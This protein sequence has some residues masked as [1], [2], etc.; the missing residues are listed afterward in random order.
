M[1]TTILTKRTCA[2][3]VP[4]LIALVETSSK[5]IG[6]AIVI[7]VTQ[8][9][10]MVLQNFQVL[11]AVTELAPAII[12]PKFDGCAV[13]HKS[14]QIA[15]TIQVFQGHDLGGGATQG[16]STIGQGAI[17]I[18]EPDLIGSIISDE[19]VKVSIAVEEGFPRL[20]VDPALMK[21]V[22]INLITNAVQAMPEGGKLT[23]RASRT[24]ETASISIQDTGVGIP[25][26]DLPRL[27]QPL[28]TT[29]PRGQGFGLPVCQRLVEAHGGS[30]TVESEVGVG[31]TFTVQ[32]PL[33]RR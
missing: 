18:V 6:S 33:R 25:G 17:A 19:S 1:P 22:L 15:V 4:D 32:I 12:P 26:E 3:V 13:S 16:L 2:I 30:I 21:R 8:G 29:K 28:F 5:D 31:S 10:N 24:G 11:T 23:I 14:I 9:H 7:H 27:F 20:M